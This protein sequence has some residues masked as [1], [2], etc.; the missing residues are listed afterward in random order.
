M[1]VR[2]IATPLDAGDTHRVGPPERHARPAKFTVHARG[3]Y[4]AAP[5]ERGAGTIVNGDDAAVRRLEG[6]RAWPTSLA[7]YQAM[8]EARE[9]DGTNSVEFTSKGDREVVTQIFFRMAYSVAGGPA[10]S[11]KAP[12]RSS[13]AL[14]LIHI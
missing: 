13:S 9:D 3:W 4:A 1:F 10:R 11:M 6:A 2:L 7:E 8:M 12:R 14:S 5:A